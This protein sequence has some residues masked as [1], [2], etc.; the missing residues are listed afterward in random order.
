[1]SSFEENSSGAAVDP[2]ET[3]ARYVISKRWVRPD[4]S[5]KQE[6]FIPPAD[7]Q[8]SVTRHK[9]LTA[10]QIW[11][12]GEGVASLRA[13]TLVGRADIQTRSVTSTG[14]QVVTA[15]IDDNPNHAHV[16]GWPEDKPQQK[17]LAQELAAFCTYVA[18]P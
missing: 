7:L 17:S 10:D 1:M 11:K 9:G 4:K 3:L 16:V 8:L 12:F 18:K 14:L 13:T 5:I 6:A 2:T 15:A